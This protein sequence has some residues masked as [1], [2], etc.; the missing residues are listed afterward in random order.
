M[1]IGIFVLGGSFKPGEAGCEGLTIN[2]S[3]MLIV[4]NRNRPDNLILRA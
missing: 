1:D 2:D 4:A 3:R